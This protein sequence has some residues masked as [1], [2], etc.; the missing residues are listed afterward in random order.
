MVDG[1]G[2]HGDGVGG[3]DAGRAQ[4]RVVERRAL[5]RAH[6]AD[7]I[8]TPAAEGMPGAVARAT[9][10]AERNRWFMPQQFRNPA[11]PDAHRRT[12]AQEIW[13]DTAGQ[14]DILVAGAGQVLKEENPD[15]TVVA[16]E[17]A[18]SAVLSGDAPGPHRIQGPGAG[19]VPDVL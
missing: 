2:E 15:I 19:F 4:L 18:E 3:V 17:S 16:V 5:L 14:G 13:H 12:T 6:C 8:L 1:V 7:L 9:E 10:L 11:N